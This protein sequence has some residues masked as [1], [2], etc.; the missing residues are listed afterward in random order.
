MD[1]KLERI[2]AQSM[3]KRQEFDAEDASNLRISKPRKSVAPNTCEGGS[4]SIA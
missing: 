2:A 1:W 3:K 4:R